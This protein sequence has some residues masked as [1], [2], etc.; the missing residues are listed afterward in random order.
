M[1]DKA[2]TNHYNHLAH[3]LNNIFTRIINSV[4]L[5]KNKLSD[6]KELIPLLNSIEFSTFMAAEIIEDFS[7][8]TD[9]KTL[10][11]KN[12]NINSLIK[13][14]VS[15][16]ETQTKDRI[17]FQ[18]VLEPK[19]YLI[20]GRYTDYYRILLNL[21]INSVEAING[22]GKVTI[23]TENK[24]LSNSRENEP[25]LFEAT[26]HIQIT[27]S[28]DGQGIDP[29]ILPFIFEEKFSTKS[30][31]KNSG[32]GLSFVKRII[33]DYDGKIKVKSEKLS[34][35]NFII[36]LPAV[37]AQ[38][39]NS[40]KSIKNKTILVAE[41]EEIQRQLLIE[42]LESY[43]YK[44]IA[45]SNGSEVL[46]HLDSE[47]LPDLLIL[48]QKMPDID[49][50]TCIQIIR[51]KKLLIPIILSSGSEGEVGKA[52]EINRLVNK[53]INKPYDFEDM[54]NTIKELVG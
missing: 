43:R 47:I 20:E 46:K 1:S 29:I 25:K 34:G 41:D 31:K 30:G 44:V 52:N 48:D 14:L 37:F 49:G 26:P 21:L 51:E 42:L 19:I 8:Q 17:K 10:K 22:K 5:I 27:I 50:L 35:T 4:E 18:T 16:V 9:N 28:D 13:D 45:V 23:L 2:S 38:H 11:K 53:I 40:S 7:S 36:T 24:K 3:D 32:I 6:N 39:R 33:E 15:T 12:I 54:L